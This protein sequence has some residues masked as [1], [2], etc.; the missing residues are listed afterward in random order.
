MALDS[1]FMLAVETDGSGNCS[2]SLGLPKNCDPESSCFFAGAFIVQLINFILG[3]VATRDTAHMD[4]NLGAPG[5]CCAFHACA[6]CAVFGLAPFAAGYH[7]A[8]FSD[9]AHDGLAD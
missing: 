3:S 8:A 6:V 2:M 9:G 1:T 7:P 4:P 5:S